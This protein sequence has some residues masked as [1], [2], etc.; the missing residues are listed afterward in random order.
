MSAQF[1]SAS[2]KWTWSTGTAE[3]QVLLGAMVA[4]D[5]QSLPRYSTESDALQAESDAI[6]YL[7]EMLLKLATQHGFYDKVDAAKKSNADG[8]TTKTNDQA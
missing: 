4:S 3:L 2:G 5:F 7:D 6:E 1:D 8:Q